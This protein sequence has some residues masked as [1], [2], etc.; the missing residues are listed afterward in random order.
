MKRS[1]LALLSMNKGATEILIYLLKIK[2][3]IKSRSKLT[4][5]FMRIII[6]H[7]IICYTNHVTGGMW[8]F[9]AAG[10]NE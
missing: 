3:T 5:Y 8:I 4:P 9:D 10:M 1:Y 2:I 7:S 6:I